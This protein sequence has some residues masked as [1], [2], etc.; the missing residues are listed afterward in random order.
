MNSEPDSIRNAIKLFE[1]AVELDSNYFTAYWNK[2]VYENQLG[3]FDDAFKTLEKLE[4]LKP[5]APYLKTFLGISM[6][7]RGDTVDAKHKFMEAD[8]LY[9]AVLDTM[10]QGTNPFWSLQLEK[11][12]NLKFLNKDIEANKVLEYIKNNVD[13][14]KE[15]EE[16][17][18]ELADT[19]LLLDK[20]TFLK[21]LKEKRQ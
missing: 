19:I 18:I 10:Q 20:N 11:A 17:F 8:V 3:K 21:S 6:W 15:D 14:D 12:K 7:S 1:Q 4:K 16:M 13:K 5:E 2:F 9:S